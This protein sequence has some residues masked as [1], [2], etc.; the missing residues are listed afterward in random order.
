MGKTAAQKTTSGGKRDG[1]ISKNFILNNFNIYKNI[2]LYGPPGTGKTLYTKELSTIIATKNIVTDLKQQ[3]RDLVNSNQIVF[4][5]FHQSY[6]YEEFMEGIKPIVNGSN[7]EYQV[8]DGIFKRQS[9]I[10]LANYLGISDVQ[11]SNVTKTIDELFSPE[12]NQHYIELKKKIK[13]KIKTKINTT[14]KKANHKNYVLIIDE[15]NRGNISQIFGELITLIE[16]DKR[17]GEPNMISVT[18]P[19]SGETFV[20]PPNLWI[21]GTMNTADRSAESLDTALRRR[22]IFIE[23]PPVYKDLV[24]ISNVNLAEMLKR[25]NDRIFLLKGKDY[26]IGH[27]YFTGLTQSNSIEDI[28]NIITY[29]ILPLLE[30]YF[31]NDYKK[32]RYVL[33]NAFAINMFSTGDR[34]FEEPLNGNWGSDWDGD[35]ISNSDE[36][37]EVVRP[38]SEEQVIKGII[39]KET[40]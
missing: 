33:G 29:S 10:A 12:N 34:E 36:F 38:L 40:S 27:G 3:Y 6:A 39:S 19:Y 16:G 15:I 4:T 20:V 24:T 31:Y 30:E 8:R 22:F 23:M 21:I 1:D 32:I 35:N 17:Y 2:I 13:A 9:I 18:L 5:T 37:I 28:H 25:I 14:K 11:V 7:V 26:E